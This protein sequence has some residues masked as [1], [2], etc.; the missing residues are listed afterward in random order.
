MNASSWIPNWF[1][2]E[3]DE[4]ERQIS[5]WCNLNA[6]KKCVVVFNLNDLK[7]FLHK[8]KLNRN[9]DG[10]HHFCSTHNLV[11]SWN[12]MEENWGILYQVK[13]N[14]EFNEILYLFCT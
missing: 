13:S 8:N 11:I 7:K 4:L 1:D 5:N 9:T 6:R 14:K 3:V 10:R 12:E 2:L